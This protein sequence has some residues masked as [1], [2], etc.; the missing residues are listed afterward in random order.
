MLA[1]TEGPQDSETCLSPAI[2]VGLLG[3]ARFTNSV[4]EAVWRSVPLVPVMVS[5]NA[6]GTVPVVVFIVSVEV[7]VPLIEGGLNPPLVIPVGNPDS[8]PTLRLT[9]PLNPLMP[10]TETV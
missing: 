8:L 1:C 6:Q 4:L 10:V 2:A 5:D 3:G 9:G 7:P